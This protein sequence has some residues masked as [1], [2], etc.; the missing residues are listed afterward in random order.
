M[1][2]AGDIST[3]RRFESYPASEMR[4]LAPQNHMCKI[5]ITY[6]PISFIC[7]GVGMFTRTRIVCM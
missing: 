7:E 4:L 2:I 6:P 3:Y 5:I 1:E